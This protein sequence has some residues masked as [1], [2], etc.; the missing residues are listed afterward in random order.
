M[1]ERDALHVTMKVNLGNGRTMTRRVELL[2]DRAGFKV[3][4]E[5][6]GKGKQLLRIHPT[7]AIGAPN[8]TSLLLYHGDKREEIPLPENEATNAYYRD[9][10]CPTGKWGFTTKVA[11]KDVIVLNTFDPSQIDF[12]YMNM[13]PEERRLNLEQ[14]SKQL[15]GH[16]TVMNTYEFVK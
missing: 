9:K 16:V 2:P 15:D 14:W 6:T 4:S 7:F 12:C 13:K 11:D 8:S 10:D 1:I 5:L 3:T